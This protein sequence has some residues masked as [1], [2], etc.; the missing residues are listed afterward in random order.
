MLAVSLGI[1]ALFLV[2][3][4]YCTYHRPK[5]GVLITLVILTFA[6]DALPWHLLPMTGV[7]V[8]VQAV[9]TVGLLGLGLFRRHARPLAGASTPYAVA[10]TAFALVIAA[11]ALVPVPH[12]YGLTKAMLF[13]VK[14]V[15][16]LWA[17]GVWGPFDKRDAQTIVIAFV[18]GAVMVAANLLISPAMSSA[19]VDDR[20]SLREDVGPIAV[21]RVIG[22]GLT[23]TMLVALF[24]TGR[25][26]WP[27]MALSVAVM[28]LLAAALLACG[29]RGPLFGMAL[30][31]AGALVL[32]WPAWPDR[33]RAVGRLAVVTAVIGGGL[34]LAPQDIDERGGLQRLLDFSSSVGENRS[35]RGR[36]LYAQMATDGIIASK[37][38]GAGTGAFSLMCGVDRE[39]PHNV[40]LEVGLEQGVL[41]LGLLALLGALVLGRIIWLS[42]SRADPLA[43]AL[44]ALFFFVLVNAS[45]SGDLT[46]NGSLWVGGG[47]VWLLRAPR[48][49]V[50]AVS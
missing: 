25:A 17:L 18:V 26:R 43:R 19:M 38:L 37:G 20:A 40:V 16:P 24:S 15:L 5:D 33:A 47:L 32:V 7:A 29:T 8:A 11:F 23:L 34:L 4:G 36:L 13:V 9:A 50:E 21:A 22:Q 45:V 41:G 35:D 46:A 49:P 28:P 27:L 2:W 31:I 44:A 30:A 48:A 6:L 42:G 39:Y 12:A 3:V 1:L 10:L 14:A